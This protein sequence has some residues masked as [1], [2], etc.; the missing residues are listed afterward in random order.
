MAMDY[1]HTEPPRLSWWAR[2]GH[3]VLLTLILATLLLWRFWPSHWPWSSLS[4]HDPA[5]KPRVIAP[6]DGLL[7]DELANIEVN[8]K[9]RKSV[10]SITTLGIQRNWLSH[11]LEEVPEGA[12]SGFIW[13][14]RGY[15]VTN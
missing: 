5:A 13:D 10:V 12:G 1:Y 3:L 2:Y 15:I 7:P 4:L 8:N 9:A 6:A 14:E 11:D